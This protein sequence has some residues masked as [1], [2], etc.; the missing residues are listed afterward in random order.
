MKKVLAIYG[1]LSFIVVFTGAMLVSLVPMLPSQT[2]AL[3]FGMAAIMPTTIV[4]L[5]MSQKK[6]TTI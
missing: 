6:R 3:L 4:S 1:L 2:D 5:A